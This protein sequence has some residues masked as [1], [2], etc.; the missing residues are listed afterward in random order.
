MI[1]NDD[2][3]LLRHLL[4]HRR[5]HRNLI[6]VHQEEDEPRFSIFPFN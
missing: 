3:R 6:E 2:L 5:R 1:V 4:H